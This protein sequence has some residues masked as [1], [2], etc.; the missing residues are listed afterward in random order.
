MNLIMGRLARHGWLAAALW[1]FS[2]SLAAQSSPEQEYKKLL[3]VSEEIQPL[4]ENPFGE[5]IS[6]YNGAISF[7]QTD[8]SLPGNGP[9]LQL[10]RS[11]H[12]T[13]PMNSEGYRNGA[14]V[15][16]DIDLPRIT[17]TV[18]TQQN[19]QG[20]MVEGPS[21]LA[22]CTQFS[23]P[24]SVNGVP[25]DSYRHSW[26]T[27]EWWNGYQ[28][29]MP[30][31]GSQDILNRAGGFYTAAP[32]MPGMV[33]PA[34]TKKHW[35]I[36]CLPHA[37]NDSA[38]EAFLAIAPDG[39]KYWFDYLVS[40]PAPIISRPVGDP[41]PPMLRSASIDVQPMV[42]AE[43]D[44]LYREYAAMLVSRVEDRFG[45]SLT[46][47]YN[48]NR[49]LAGITAS[50]GRSVTIQYSSPTGPASTITAQP[51]AGG[52]RTWTYQY[53]DYNRGQLV[54]SD[55]ALPDHSH[56]KFN[57]GDLAYKVTLTTV[58]EGD[59]DAPASASNP[60]GW[61]GSM[62]HP[63]GLTGSFSVAAQK[64]GRSYV[65]QGCWGGDS[66]AGVAAGY[67]LTP[68]AWYSFTIKQKVFSGAGLPSPQTWIYQY[69]PANESW[70][71]NCPTPSSCPSTVW[72]D[73]IAPDGR[74]TRYT[75]SNRFDITEGQ[76]QRTDAYISGVGSGVARSQISSYAAPDS[77]PWPLYF[78]D[79]MQG[80]RSN[81]WVTSQETP[82][83]R[84]VLQQDG[85]SYIWQATG[86]N[87]FA[88]V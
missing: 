74:A 32:Q 57:L 53:T 56:W 39:T 81:T 31:E 71:K 18:A 1:L 35:M 6:L 46:Y 7:S 66:I 64:H 58:R 62:V 87:A 21:P 50:D 29:V 79:D 49:R 54:L 2:T 48:S 80:D 61:A 68:N 84:Q 69:S 23:R 26:K 20:W 76:L 19:V 10:M 82:L 17:T 52:G 41:S 25:G 47:S 27:Y 45:N 86:F 14:F 72:T 3:K 9:L 43:T 28:L 59:C 42:S 44:D 34:L 30:G 16:W 4:G 22:I 85:D 70:T 13:D 37:A 60:V 33:F 55:V 5:N 8:V 83:S 12:V 77:G 15:D 78:G 40:S 24:P 65:Y 67:A 51:N 11:F 73:V 36:G 75:F 88:Q 63:S 38:R